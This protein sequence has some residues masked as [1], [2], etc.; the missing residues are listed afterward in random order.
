MKPVKA[1]GW[2]GAPNFGDALSVPLLRHWAQVD[3]ELTD[4]AHEADVVA[5]GST[6]GHMPAGWSGTVLGAGKMFGHEAFPPLARVR[7]V[8]GRLSHPGRGVV[9]GDP[10]L[11]ADELVETPSRIHKLGIIDHWSSQALRTR[12]EWWRFD[13]LYI[14]PASGP[15]SVIA[16]IGSCEKIIS[17]G[18]HGAVIAH[19]FGIPVRL[20]PAAQLAR[21]GGL[22]KFADHYS[23]IGLELKTGVTQDVPRFR[24]NDVRDDL[25]DM[26]EEYGEEVRHAS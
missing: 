20:E 3:A 26:F 24:I 15:L 2:T 22:F 9:Y 11:I 4:N 10:G 14:D 1:Y 19:A 18:L 7:G 6:I 17:G 5:V 25:I 21:E 8:R 16:A 12:S 13:P 23:T